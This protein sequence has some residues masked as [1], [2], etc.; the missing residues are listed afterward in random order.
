MSILPQKK[1]VRTDR[2][3]FKQEAEPLAKI[4]SVKMEDDT[5]QPNELNCHLKVMKTYLKAR[6]RLSVLLGAQKMIA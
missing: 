5:H 2:Q 1:V 4:W 6:Y 3:A